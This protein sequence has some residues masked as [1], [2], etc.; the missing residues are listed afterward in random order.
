MLNSINLT[1]EFA[2]HKQNS[3]EHAQYSWGPKIGH[4]Q[5]RTL[6]DL[7]SVWPWNIWG[8]DYISVWCQYKR[9]FSFCLFPFLFCSANRV[10]KL[11]VH[12]NR[13]QVSSIFQNI[14]HAMTI[15]RHILNL[16]NGWKKWIRQCFWSSVRLVEAALFLSRTPL[17]AVPSCPPQPVLYC[18]LKN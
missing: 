17:V 12:C 9:F 2:S 11:K 16:W 10:R 18:S 1:F 15:W 5:N 4:A 3:G 7:P 13:T 8:R 14:Q 6:L